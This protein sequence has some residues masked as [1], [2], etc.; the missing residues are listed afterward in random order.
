MVRSLVEPVMSGAV[1]SG[2]G[3]ALVTSRCGCSA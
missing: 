1:P 2:A 3:V